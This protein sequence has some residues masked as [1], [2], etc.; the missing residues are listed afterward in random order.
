LKRLRVLASSSIVGADLKWLLAEY[1]RLTRKHDHA[2]AVVGELAALVPIS[3]TIEATRTGATMVQWFKEHLRPAH[4][5][6]ALRWS[7][8]PPTV[9]GTWLVQYETQRYEALEVAP[10]A[11]ILRM[12]G[13]PYGARRHASLDESPVEPSGERCI[14][15]PCMLPRGHQGICSS[16]PLGPTSA[17]SAAGTLNAEAS[18]SGEVSRSATVGADPL[19]QLEDDETFGQIVEE[20]QAKEGRPK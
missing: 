10:G 4:E 15:W 9:S 2:T 6:S 12:T 1:D 20:L 5:T 14:N 7:A 19:A 16:S 17:P 13:N 18:L 8:G 11:P 3:E